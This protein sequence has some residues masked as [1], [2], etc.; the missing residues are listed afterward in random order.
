MSFN[1]MHV[2]TD[3]VSCYF[4]IDEYHSVVLGTRFSPF[5]SRQGVHELHLHFGNGF[6]A[7][8]NVH[9]QVSLE[10]NGKYFL[11]QKELQTKCL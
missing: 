9:M 8:I 1:T 5:I 7:K 3:F 10:K 2:P 11:C 6:S 4:L